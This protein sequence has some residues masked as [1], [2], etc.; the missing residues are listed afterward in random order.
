MG[1]G[2]GEMGRDRG[3]FRVRNLYD[4]EGENNAH[5]DNE[6]PVGMQNSLGMD[7]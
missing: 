1:G 6:L 5:N 4:G 3:P 7:E 2:G